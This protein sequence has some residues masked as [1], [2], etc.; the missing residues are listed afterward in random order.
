MASTESI[1]GSNCMT[2]H[3]MYADIRSS[4]DYSFHRNYEEARQKFQ[5]DII[6]KMTKTVHSPCKEMENHAHPRRPWIIFTAGAMGVGKSQAVRR[7]ISEGKLPLRNFIWV[8]PDDIRVTLPEFSSYSKQCRIRA[9]ELTQKESGYIAEITTL[10]ALR[11]GRNVLVEG[12]LRDAAWYRNYFFRLRRECRGINIIILYVVAPREV[13]L[14]RA[15]HRARATGRAIPTKTLEEA[16]TQVP[17]SIKVLEKLAD[18]CL[19]VD[20][21]K[22]QLTLKVRARAREHNSAT[23]DNEISLVKTASDALDSDTNDS[24]VTMVCVPST[25]ESFSN[26]WVLIS[27]IQ[28]IVT[29]TLVAVLLWSQRFM[30][31]K[32]L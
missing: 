18:C 10:A 7:L 31:H 29:C 8:D 30:N 11:E 23:A 24:I 27:A 3:G 28:V 22:E 13:V 5:D 2:F 1:H 20:S 12:S 25:V 21:S 16:L 26:F 14:Q 6:G 32:H 4:L 17:K 15:A 19:E 9:G